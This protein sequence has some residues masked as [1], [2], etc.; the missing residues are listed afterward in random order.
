MRSIRGR[1]LSRLLFVAL[2]PLSAAAQTQD[3][4]DRAIRLDQAIQ[5]LKDEVLDVSRDAQA[6]ENAVLA[7]EDQRV[8]IYVSL[9]IRGLLLDEIRIAIDGG[10]DELYR[11][12][13]TEARALLAANSA[14]RVLRTAVAVGPHRIRFSYSGRY[15]D[16]APDSPP[17]TGQYEAI[18]DKDYRESE[19]E[20]HLSR[21]SRFG[22][23]I[24]TSMKE[25]RRQR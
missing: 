16:T 17:V 18:F 13:E 25:W 23:Q 7:P 11:Y 9:A 2:L 24:R 10:P 1:S 19:L 4:T 15:A 21:A 5:A 3:M 20:F 6:V 14:Q 22:D 12:D 8:S